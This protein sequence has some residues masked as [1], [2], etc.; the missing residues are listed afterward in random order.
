M[1]EKERLGDEIKS[2]SGLGGRTR[3]ASDDAEGEKKGFGLQ[4]PGPLPR[5][6][7]TIP[8]RRIILSGILIAANSTPTIPTT[9]PGHSDCS[10]Q[11]L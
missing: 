6:A 10:L 2:A 4:Y 3:Q 5:Y 8:Q 7:S 11:V 9:F 1:E